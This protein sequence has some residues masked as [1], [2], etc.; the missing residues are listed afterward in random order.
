MYSWIGSPYE[1]WGPNRPKK[2]GNVSNFENGSR[3]KDTT[4]DRYKYT[5]MPI[6][7]PNYLK[8]MDISIVKVPYILQ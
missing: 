1:H 5:D 3:V 7:I 2:T 6:D 4:W 8:T